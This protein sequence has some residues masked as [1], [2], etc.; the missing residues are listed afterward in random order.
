MAV[1]AA[2]PEQVSVYEAVPAAVGVT[3]SVPLVGCV[4]L[5][6]PLA[7]QDV[8]FVE[9]QVSVALC[10][11]ASEAGLIESVTLGAAALTVNVADALALPPAPLQ[12]SV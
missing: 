6:A 12:V 10:P 9:D 8:A 2:A 4:P 3:V 5:Q 7:V 11:S 1:A